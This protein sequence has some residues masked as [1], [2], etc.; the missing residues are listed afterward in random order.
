[1]GRLNKAL[2]KKVW[3]SKKPLP[4]LSNSAAKVRVPGVACMTSCLSRASW[5]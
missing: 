1:M 4:G 5:R 3:P 2:A